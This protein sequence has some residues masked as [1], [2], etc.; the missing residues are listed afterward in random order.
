MSV[1]QS[2]RFQWNREWVPD[3]TNFNKLHHL[4][5]KTVGSI[6]TESGFLMARFQTTATPLKQNGRFQWNR[7]WLSHGRISTDCNTSQARWSDPVEPRV[8]SWRQDFKKLQHL[9]NQTVGS[10]GTN[11]GFLMAEFRQIATPPKQDGGFQ[12]NREWVPGGRVS[13]NGNT[14]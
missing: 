10:S 5:S 11:R 4:S 3:G 12:W 7:Q 2:D 6:G 14:S 9:S 1:V 8:G 13:I